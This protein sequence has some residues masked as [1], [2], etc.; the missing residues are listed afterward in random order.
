V[1]SSA[2]SLALSHVTGCRPLHSL[3]YI[4]P[5]NVGYINPVINGLLFVQLSRHTEQCLAVMFIH[6]TGVAFRGLFFAAYFCFGFF[7]VIFLF[8][9]KL[10]TCLL[11]LIQYTYIN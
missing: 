10:V 2:L 6:S 11:T 3:L 5:T 7:S 4:N 9:D 1:H 8:I